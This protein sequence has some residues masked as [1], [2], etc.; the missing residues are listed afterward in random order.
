MFIT[1]TSFQ[2]YHAIFPAEYLQY[3]HD[4]EYDEQKITT[5]ITLSST[6]LYNFCDPGE[7]GEW[8]EVVIAL[9]EYLRSGESKV[10]F[11]NKSLQK[12]MLHKSGERE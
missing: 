9:I 8:L 10:G 3:I 1:H 11:L 6:K 4:T 7:R 12:N 2:L 5:E